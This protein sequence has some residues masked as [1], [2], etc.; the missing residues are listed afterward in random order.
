MKTK[1]PLLFCSGLCGAMALWAPAA[2]AQ[3]APAGVTA[4][5]TVDPPPAVVV[6][7]PAPAP[8]TVVVEAAPRRDARPRYYPGLIWGGVTVWGV[9]YATAAIGA[10]VANDACDVDQRLC[11]RGR[12]ILLVPVAGPFVAMTAVNGNGSST[13]KTL[14]AIDGAFQAGGVAMV[15][16][17]IILS[18]HGASTSSVAATE[19]LTEHKFFVSPYVTASSAG[20]GAAGHF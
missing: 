4:Q 5:V 6:Q 12:G 7:P 10:A 16:T 3:S 9:S 14:L 13:V 19:P 15:L 1:T 20:L 2:L 17:G 11:I 18:I 8:E